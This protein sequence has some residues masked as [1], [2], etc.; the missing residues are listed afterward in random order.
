MKLLDFLFGWTG[1]DP[2]FFFLSGITIILNVTLLLLLQYV[3]LRCFLRVR[4]RTAV[5]LNVGLVV[6]CA[7]FYLWAPVLLSNTGIGQAVGLGLY[8]LLFM[9]LSFFLFRG[10]AAQ[11]LFMIAYAN[12]MCVFVLGIGNWLEFSFGEV[13]FPGINSV[14]A[15]LARL[16]LFPIVLPLCICSLKK[17]FSAWSG[18][19]AASFWITVWL[20][21]VALSVLT[22]FS[23]SART[24]T[25]ANSLSFLLSRILS[26]FA[27]LTCTNLMTSIMK[28]EQKTAAAQTREQ[29]MDV[30]GRTRD[31][32]YTEIL[33]AWDATN[34]TRRDVRMV[35]EQIMA[36]TQRGDYDKISA[37]LR[38]RMEGLD[39]SPERFCENEAV[40]ALALHYV[41]LARAEGIRVTYH[42]AIPKKAGRVQNVDLSR[43]VGNMLENA[44]EA[45]CRMECGERYIQLKSIIQNDMLVLVMDNSF[46][47]E[48]V[49]LPNGRYVSRKR[50]SGVATGLSSIETVTDRYDGTA[51]FEAGNRVFKTSIRLDMVGTQ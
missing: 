5:L 35:L 42:L 43:I 3:P 20:I 22:M 12:C 23:G 21:P 39:A 48:F 7:G 41:A 9:P 49:V 26:I 38:E 16:V 45:C 25:D 24:L 14:V 46:D 33:S 37:I 10:Y 27:L 15:V 28:R 51:L 4:L 44:I 36:C 19:T 32:S 34:T 8:I 47:G 50:K 18:V 2:L 29:M 30:A 1:Y 11:N 31:K 40:N 17:M 6:L 13:L